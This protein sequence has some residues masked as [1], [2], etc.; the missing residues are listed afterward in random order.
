MALTAGCPRCDGPVTVD[1]TGVTCQVHG[2][3]PP[4]WRPLAASYDDLGE[5]LLAAGDFPTWLPW[6][7]GSGWTVSDVAR[8]G[9]AP[10][11]ATASRITGETPQ[12]GPV[13]L[14]VVG[15]EP[16]TGYGARLA[17]L[18]SVDPGPDV[19]RG[20][21]VA[22][23]RLGTRPVALWL[24]SPGAERDELGGSAL[25]GSIGDRSIGDLSIGD[26][27]IGDRSIGDRS[28]LVGEA[29]GR[30]LWWVVRPA[31]ALLLLQDGWTL[32]DASRIGPA[33]LEL[34]FGGPAYRW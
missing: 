27:S 31:S 6:P 20:S 8:V 21:P 2:P 13:D 16:G 28:V 19:G 34:P 3:V 23:V 25:G 18:A 14:C 29:A 30:W 7:L 24:V 4:L 26:L 15:E 22:H 10:V 12:D 9:D 17:G 11:L 1:A 5:H 32:E 33:L